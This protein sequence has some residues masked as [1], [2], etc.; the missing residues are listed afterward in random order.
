MRYIN[1]RSLPSLPLVVVV[2]VLRTVYVIMYVLCV[3][4]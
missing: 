3:D 4:C 1:R 2:A